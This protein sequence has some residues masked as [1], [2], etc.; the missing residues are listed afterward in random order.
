MPLQV[1]EGNKESVKLEVQDCL[2][3]PSQSGKNFE[4]CDD[5]SAMKMK[6]FRA[7]KENVLERPRRKKYISKRCILH[8]KFRICNEDCTSYKGGAPAQAEITY[9]KESIE[10]Y[11][12]QTIMVKTC[13]TK[14]SKNRNSHKH[15]PKM[16]LLN[17]AQPWT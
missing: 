17:L 6:K 8:N 3:V 14:F 1:K 10:M 7:W 16:F 4:R 5:A 15:Q 12:P 13:L 9:Y 11:Q 2:K